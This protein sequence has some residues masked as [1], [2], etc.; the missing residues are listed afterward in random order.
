M[1]VVG[2]EINVGMRARCTPERQV[3]GRRGIPLR[4][5]I[6][7]LRRLRPGGDSDAA[8]PLLHVL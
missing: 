5:T 4:Q 1:I 6:F 8:R 3:W 7:A 2:W